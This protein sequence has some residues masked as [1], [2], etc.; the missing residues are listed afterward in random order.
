VTIESRVQ[1]LLVVEDN[2]LTREGLGVV[3]QQEGYQV[4]LAAN[5]QA[6]LDHLGTGPRPDLVLLDMLMPVLDGWHFLGKFQQGKTNAIPVV[7]VT[8]TNL[9]HEWAQ[10]HGCQGFL[11]KPVEAEGLL[12]EVRRRLGGPRPPGRGRA[13]LSGLPGRPSTI[14]WSGSQ[15][16]IAV[17]DGG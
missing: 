2:R 1:T 16:A 14:P 11:R 9:T 15:A 5:G 6:A 13:F 8:G 3:L 12:A 10:D 4:A 17:G 7:I